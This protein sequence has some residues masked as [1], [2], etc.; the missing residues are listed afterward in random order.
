MKFPPKY[1]F[2]YSSYYITI[3]F[4]LCVFSTPPIAH[5][6]QCESTH[7]LWWSIRVD[8]YCNWTIRVVPYLS[9]SWNY[10]LWW[11][12]YG[13][14]T[15][16]GGLLSQTIYLCVSQLLWT[17]LCELIVIK[18]NICVSDPH[19]HSFCNFQHIFCHHFNFYCFT[20]CLRMFQAA[21]G[22]TWLPSC[23]PLLARFIA[24]F[25]QVQFGLRKRWLCCNN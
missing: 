15:I 1:L 19:F 3:Y 2:T 12:I 10:S 13:G 4:I 18:I 11:L 25:R 7:I 23:F 8:P 21:G 17:F 22:Y 5:I 6:V 16:F 9:V 24:K 14:L 20:Y